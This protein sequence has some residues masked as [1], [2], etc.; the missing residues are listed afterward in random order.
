MKKLF[1]ILL[2]LLAMAACTS[3]FDKM[4][5]DAGRA[6]RAGDGAVFYATIEDTGAAGTQ[7]KVYADEQLRVL[8]NSDDMISIFNKKTANLKYQFDGE[9]GDNAGTFTKVSESAATG[10]DL[11]YVYAIYPYQEATSISENGEIS[12]VLPAVQ[13]YKANSFGPEVNT[14]VS[15]SEG[16]NLL[17]KNVGGYLSFKLYG[18]DVKVKSITLRGNN[19]EK[20]AGAALISMPYGG[21]P[22]VTMQESA[23]D[24][25]TLTC[26]TPVMLGTTAEDYTEFW[27]VLP[28]TSFSKGFTISVFDDQGGLFEKSTSKFV[29]ISRNTLSYMAPVEVVPNYDPLVVER[30]ALVALYN[31]LDGDNW[32]HK[33][34]WCSDKPVG[35]WYG[36][37]TLEGV[38]RE[39]DLR[40]NNLVG[41]LPEA[42]SNLRNLSYLE[43]RGNHITGGLPSWLTR[44]VS[45]GTLGLGGNPLGGSI[46]EHIGDL[47]NLESLSLYDDGLT[48]CIPESIGR[49]TKLTGLSLGGNYLEGC[50]P[51]TIINCSELRWLVLKEN[52]Y[53]SGPIPTNIGNL[54]KLEGLSLSSNSLSGPIPNSLSQLHE[55]QHLD[56]ENNSLSGRIPD[57]FDQLPNLV[58]IYL[59]HNSFTGEIPSTL[60]TLEHVEALYLSNNKLYGIVPEWITKFIVPGGGLDLINNMFSGKIPDG[61]QN[62][63]EWQNIWYSIV[64]YNNFSMDDVVIPAPDFDLIGIDGGSLDSDVEYSNNRYL[65]HFQWASWCGQ[66]ATLYPRIIDLYEKYHNQGFDVIGACYEELPVIN[67][68]I[69][70]YE[71]PWRTYQQSSTNKIRHSDYLNF[72]ESYP[73]FDIPLVTIFDCATKTVCFNNALNDISELEEFLKEKIEG[74]VTDQLYTSSDYSMD[75]QVRT[76]SSHSRKLNLLLMGDGFSDRLIDDGTYDNA[77]DKAVNAFFSEEPYKSSRDLFSIYSIYVVSKNEGYE[78]YGKTALDTYF[79]DGSFVGGKDGRVISYGLKAIPSDDLDNTVIIVVMNKDAYAGTCYLYSPSDGDY[80]QGL[81]IAY[82]PTSSDT[83]TFNGLVSHEAGGHGFAKLADEYAYEYMGAVPQREIDAASQMATYGWWKN[84]DFTNDPTQVKWA[85]FITDARYTNEGIGVYEGAYTYWTGA[86]RPTE[87]SIMRYNTGGFNAPSRYAIWYRIGKLAYGE[88][89]N[90]SYE[91]FVSYDV[92]NRASSDAAYPKTKSRNYVEK[93]LPPLAPPVVVGHSWREELK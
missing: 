85:Q 21:T 93:Q 80:G 39:I 71:M 34:N 35:E 84:I 16:N 30:A 38:V 20:L 25:V 19:E 1:L 11:P 62:H 70:Q 66:A 88:N 48:G 75:G 7:T 89:W 32:I 65:M 59:R 55:L 77:I 49:C 83:D 8:W 46:P 43:M 29:T 81:S 10:S 63:P 45:L 52:G 24:Y 15:V 2:T 58:R 36:I 64:G 18:S 79:G 3:E 73:D 44:M 41:S 6:S 78:E 51:A 91:D 47:V 90:G 53:L 74:Y 92:V 4:L 86:W 57:F 28:P 60:E 9:D 12:F 82:F 26:E 87:N 17:F 33:D 37:R 13:Q 56:L 42:L 50:I 14:M 68:I 67:S 72:D 27:F 76:I 22:T 61:I 40:E 54:T 23:T 31:A 69:E 5:N